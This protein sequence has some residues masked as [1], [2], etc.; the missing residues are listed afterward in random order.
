MNPTVTEH[1][2]EQL[3]QMIVDQGTELER[4]ITS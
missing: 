2:M 3:I 1:Q 4:E